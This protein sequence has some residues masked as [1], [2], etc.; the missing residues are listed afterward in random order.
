M[1]VVR[2]DKWLF[3]GECCGN[4]VFEYKAHPDQRMLVKEAKYVDVDHNIV[5]RL[6][7]THVD[8]EPADIPVIRRHFKEC[9]NK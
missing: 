8:E 1:M 2:S 3:V 7:A 6:F 9:L 4:L 5:Y